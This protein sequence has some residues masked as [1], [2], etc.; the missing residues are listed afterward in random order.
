MSVDAIVL[1]VAHSI[2][3]NKLAD[4]HLV[5]VKLVQ[6]VTFVATFAGVS[7]PVDADL[8]FALLVANFVLVRKHVGLHFVVAH[9]LVD[10]P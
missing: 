8:L 6:K 9:L 7:E 4:W 2:L 5:D 3:L 1:L 10:V